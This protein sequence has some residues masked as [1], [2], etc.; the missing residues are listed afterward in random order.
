MSES[1][2]LVHLYKDLHA[3]PELSFQEH[4]TAAIVTKQMRRLGLSVTEGI[5]GTGVA[6]VLEN[7]AGPVVWLRA[8]M[9]ALPVAEKTGLEYAS[10]A[11][12]V[13]PDGI[14]SPVMHACGHDMHVTW[15]IGAMEH[16]SADRAEWAGTVVAIFQPAEETLV[17]AKAMI[18][19]G[20]LDRVPL[21]L[22]GGRSAGDGKPESASAGGP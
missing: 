9:D 10:A 12:A 22:V 19:D 6:A 18:D 2:S 21:A 20:L 17:G 4:R 7:G 1:T 15:L 3:H 11:S 8:D 13:G 14:E 5:G 16:L